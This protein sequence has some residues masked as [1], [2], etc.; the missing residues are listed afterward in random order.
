LAPSAAATA[1]GPADA[2]PAALTSPEQA[3]GPSG[4][5]PGPDHPGRAEAGAR[6]EACAPVEAC[7]LAYVS[8]TSGTTGEPSAVLI[9]HRSLDNYLRLVVRDYGLGP[10]TVA[11][12]V[13]PLG[14]DASIRDTFAPLL[15]GGRL[16]LLPRGDVL[17]PESF[18]A[19]VRRHGVNTLLSVTPS[20]LSHLA[21]REEA[22]ELLDGVALVVSSGESLRP[23]LTAGGRELVRGRLVNQY[24]PTECTM[25]STRYAV[26]VAPETETDIVGTPLDGVVVRLL[27]DSLAPVPDGAVGEVFIGGAGVARGYRA[28]PGRTADRFVPDP[29]GPPGA[30]LY[31]TG[32][33]ARLGPAGLCYLGRGDRQIKIRG[34]RVDPAEIEGALLTHDAVTGAVVISD[35]DAQGRVF[36]VAHVTGELGGTS[37][38]ALRLHLARTLPPHLMPRR[39]VRLTTLPTTR[40]GK[41][42][43]TALAQAGAAR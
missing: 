16:V 28:R 23:Y 39:F 3:S 24:G 17:R 40:G 41:T 21:G 25:T 9:E 37:D 1:P 4:T 30:R 42:D 36:L 29:L 12:Q 31:R 38:P 15:A 6:A 34:Y 33:L 7:G 35:T 2:G 18:G 11:L 5:T 43:R 19:A 22:P 8:H 26:P 27:D 32:D 14:Y 10:D 20:F 13:A